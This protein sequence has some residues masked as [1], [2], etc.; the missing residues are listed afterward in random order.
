MGM[1]P[2]IALKKVAFIVALARKGE[3]VSLSLAGRSRE[4][5]IEEFNSPIENSDVA[6]RIVG[7]KGILN[8]FPIFQYLGKR[9][10]SS[11]S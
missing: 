3:V 1:A 5:L 6:F 9:F 7:N 8:Q 10:K 2:L 11:A 4:Q